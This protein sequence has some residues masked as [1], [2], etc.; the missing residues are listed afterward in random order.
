MLELLLEGGGKCWV[1]EEYENMIVITD[2]VV[3]VILSNGLCCGV[4]LISTIAIII[5]LF[6]Q[7]RR[8]NELTNSSSNSQKEFQIT[9]M[10]VTVTS[11]FII[12]R[13]PGMIIVQVS[14]VG[15]E[16]FIKFESWVKFSV[17]LTIINHSVNFFVYLIFL[18]SFRKTFLTMFPIFCCF[19]RRKQKRATVKNKGRA[20]DVGVQEAKETDTLPCSSLE[21]RENALKVFTIEIEN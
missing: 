12:L 13:L 10:V 20:D 2:L 9:V 21:A 8:R 1:K 18:E 15:A 16:I 6:R 14:L 5:C 3:H 7:K 4:I 17:L 11:L 19:C